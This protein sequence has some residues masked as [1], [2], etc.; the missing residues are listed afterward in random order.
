MIYFNNAATTYPKPQCV[1]DACTAVFHKLPEGQYRST[2][3]SGRGDIFSDCRE[4][5]G[6]LFGIREDKRIHFTSGSTEALNKILYGLRIPA[7]QILTTV[8]EHN[9]VLRPLYNMPSVKGEPVIVPCDKIGRV[10]PEAIKQKITADKNIRAVI[11][12][13]CSNVT[14]YIQE[15]DEIAGMVKER[16]LLLIVDISQSGGCIPVDADGWGADA[17]AFTGHKSLFGIQ[18]S[19]GYYVRSG[20]PF[21]PMFFGGSGKDSERLIYDE[22]NYEYDTGTQNGMG[23]AALSAGADYILDRGVETIQVGEQEKIGYLYQ[24]LSGNTKIVT[25]GKEKENKGPV[26]S[27]NIRGLA[28][29]DTAYILQNGYGIVT[30]AGL[31]CAPLIYAYLGTEKNG[32]VRAG[33]SDL[34]T[35]AE[36]EEFVRAVREICNC[37]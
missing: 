23:A 11:I 15:M 35:W 24:E 28:A 9:S 10:S 25:Y 30:R 19:G 12:N 5:L 18:G 31:H 8:T 26:F 4:K 6:R 2:E 3:S 20:I 33:I 13:H 36:T 7:G 16:G 14:G 22:E 1:Q 37:V 29:S 32:T 21:S 27:F 17:L 34:N